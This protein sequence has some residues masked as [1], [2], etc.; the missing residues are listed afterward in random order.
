MCQ[1]PGPWPSSLKWVLPMKIR[2]SHGK[3][4]CFHLICTMASTRMFLG[5]H[6]G[7]CAARGLQSYI[8]RTHYKKERRSNSHC[9]TERPMM[10]W[11]LIKLTFTEAT[12]SK[13]IKRLFVALHGSKCAARVEI[14]CTMQL[15]RVVLP[16]LMTLLRWDALCFTADS[17][18]IA[19]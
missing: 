10:L 3:K 7:P 6:S 13:H 14:S 19:T 5:S 17:R 15:S 1:S 11:K 9:G 16:P 18:D 8:A 2:G 4:V 12:R